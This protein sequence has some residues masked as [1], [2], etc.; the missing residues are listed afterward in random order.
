[1]STSIRFKLSF[2]MFLEFFI[3]GA[4]FVTLGT[5]LS[6]NLQA[7]PL[8]IANVFSTQSLGAIIA[9]FIIGMI[10]DRY[11]NA[12]RI[13]GVLHIIGA[14][15]MYQMYN[16]TEIS[17]FYPYVLAYMVLYMPTLSL[18]NSVSFRQ[19]TNPEKQFSNIRIWGTIGWIIA[20][21]S[22]SYL[23]KWDAAEASSAGALKN[24]FLMGAIASL[25]LGLFSFTL[26]KTP[27]VKIESDQKPSFSSIIGLD[28]IKLLKDRNFLIFFVSSILIC[29]PLAFY[30]QN[31][32]P[33]LDQIGMENPTG[34]MTIGQIS[35]VLFL[36]A[37]PVFFSK[38]GFKKTILVGMLAWALRYIL[39]AYGNAG[40]L[41]FMLILGIALHGIC[42][43]FFFVSG[44]IYTD[45][46]AGIKYKSAAQGLITLATYGVGQLIGFWV[47]GF[48]GEKY[49]YLQQ[50]N[51]ADFWKQTWIIPAGIA[52][53]VFVI[54]L[55]AFKDEKVEN[56]A[57][58]E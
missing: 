14:V 25:V 10:A 32:N 21:L 42:Y 38:F 5:Y 16:A 47:A 51:V 3:W 58:A 56:K 57:V 7:Q 53:V 18:V 26:P 20:G 50:A 55:V 9:P 34:K 13:L 43:D 11:F 27:P 33:F 19:L 8:E 45:S 22:I 48:I 15:L 28:A 36:L 24:T 23:F 2:M 44:Q 41:S 54:F 46:K 49:A 12:E 29:I 6:K 4:W 52:F 1:M 17:S 39:F 30:Y 31:A 35:E 40:D 37:L